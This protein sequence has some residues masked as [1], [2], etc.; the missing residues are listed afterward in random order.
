MAR[1]LTK[2]EIEALQARTLS[3]IG[4]KWDTQKLL[5]PRL[6]TIF[7]QVANKAPFDNKV[8]LTSEMT[9]A[10]VP[11]GVIVADTGQDEEFV[12]DDGLYLEDMPIKFPGSEYR[13]PKIIWDNFG[14]LLIQQMELEKAVNPDIDDQYVYLTI[15]QGMVKPKTTQRPPGTHIDGFQKPI[16]VPQIAQ[17]QISVTNT[18]PTIF[19]AAAAKPE[20]TGLVKK[21]FFKA[22]AQDC[23]G[24]PTF[25]PQPYEIHLLNAYCPHRPD[26]ATQEAFRTFVR[27]SISSIPFMGSYNTRNSLFDYEWTDE[28]KAAYYASITKPE[29]K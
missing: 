19:Y 14:D 17:H 26:K 23:E 7:G 29:F 27:F 21:E 24:Q 20:T 22:L 6:P 11:E 2:A 25:S 8:T 15:Q 4:S 5:L 12:T 3:E 18:L 28:K 9:M 10:D 16:I 13:V 1:T